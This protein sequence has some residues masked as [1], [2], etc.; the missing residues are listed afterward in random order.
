LAG[1]GSESERPGIGLTSPGRALALLAL[2]PIATREADQRE[3]EEREERERGEAEKQARKRQR[4]LEEAL[5]KIPELPRPNRPNEPIVEQFDSERF[6]MTL[7]LIPVFLIWVGNWVSHKTIF[8]SGYP[9][10]P[11]LLL[12][13]L[14]ATLNGFWS[15]LKTMPARERFRTELQ[16]YEAAIRE[17]DSRDAQRAKIRAEFEG[18]AK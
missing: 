4:E 1:E 17:A 18:N 11:M 2:A 15:V 13:V 6:F 16:G 10:F 8:E 12:P 3:R 9:W 7:W 5:A 14:L